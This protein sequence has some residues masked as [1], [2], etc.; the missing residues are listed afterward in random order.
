MPCPL[1]GGGQNRYEIG[2][3][4]GK[5]VSWTTKR[6][7]I[8]LIRAVSAI[9]REGYARI[10]KYCLG[11]KFCGYV[12]G[13]SWLSTL[14]YRLLALLVSCGEYILCNGNF[15]EVSDSWRPHRFFSHLPHW[16][17]ANK[18]DFW[19]MGCCKSF[20]IWPINID[21][22]SSQLD[23]I[24]YSRLVDVRAGLIAPTQSIRMYNS[25][26]Y[27]SLLKMI[28]SCWT[29]IGALLHSTRSFVRRRITE[30]V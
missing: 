22:A 11:Y 12:I 19:L 14:M 29:W 1:E 28:L 18:G 25:H 26:L 7:H 16:A 8:D 13:Y 17:H 6:N 10:Y 27:N 3:E 5:C 9:F 30:L 23:Y 2:W 4:C 20:D 24:S 15:P 21:T